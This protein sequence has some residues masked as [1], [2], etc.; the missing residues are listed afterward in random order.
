[1]A[2][3]L[4]FVLEGRDRLSRVL[5]G[6][7]TSASNLEKKLLLVSAAAP[8]AAALAPLIAQTGAAAVAV[9][10][11]G[12]AVIPQISALSDASDAQKK[13]QKAV[14]TSGTRSEAAVT[15]QKEYL[16]QMAAMPPASQR[17]AVALSDLK[18]QYKSWS[19]GLAKDTMPVFNKSLAVAGG[20]LPKLTPMVKGAATELDR[21]VTIAAGGVQSSGFARFMGTFSDFAV[22]S[23][24]R[25]N[26]GLVHLVRTLD[27]G[28]A[29][30]G[31]ARFMDFARAQG[32]LVADTLR[33]IAS[34]ALNL[35]QAS[36]QTGVGVLTLANAAARL[37]AAL[38]PGFIALLMQT[39]LAIRAVRLAISGVQLA[40]G[41]LT[42]VRTQIAAAGT[43]AIGASGG[44]ATLKAAFMA[45][46]LS[47]RTAV[48]ATGI[49][50]LVLGLIK[51]SSIG[52]KAP[53]DIDRMTTSIAKLGN[54]G[55]L[56]GEALRVLGTDMGSLSAAISTLD[57]P[58]VYESVDR[59]LT[60]LIGMDSTPDK[61]ANKVLDSLDESLANLVKGGKAD[62]AKVALD[63]IT[64]SMVKQGHSVSEVKGHM[65]NYQS[66]L[67]DAA[68]EAKLTAQSMGLFGTQAQQVQA[69]LDAQKLSADGLRQSIQALNDVNRQ[70]L[71]GMIGFEAAI[72]A[73]TKAAKDNAGALSMS[74]GQLNLNS[75][76][77][78]AAA[79]A[80]N[81]LAAKTDTATAAAR[82]QGKAW[83]AIQD[84]YTR[85]RNKLIE[86][87]MAMGLTASQAK[88]LADQILK[89]PSKTAYLRGNVE[90]LD[91]KLTKARKELKDPDLTKTRKAKLNADIAELLQ[92][93][94]Q[95]Q[96]A[97]DSL[98]GKTVTL[99]TYSKYVS[100]GKQ[101]GT[102]T[103][104]APGR[105]AGGPIVGPGTG[106][107]DDVP[108]MASNG[109]Y[110]VRSAAVSKYG[111]KFL[112]ALNNG[113]LRAFAKGG[114]VGGISKSALSSIRTDTGHRM[115]I[116]L[117]ASASQINSMV[118]ELVGDI[119]RAFKGKN[120]RLDDHLVAM[121]EKGNKRLKTL[122]AE[123]DSIAKKI[124]EAKAFASSTAAT[125]RGTA[126]LSSLG[127]EALTGHGG[128]VVAGLQSKLANLRQFSRYVSILAKR[129]LNKT[130]LREILEM[131]PESGFAY[132]SEL[133]GSSQ[134]TISEINGIQ[135]QIGKESKAL[136]N[137][138]A[139][140]L[141]DS[142]KNAGKGFLA[143]LAGQQK[144]IEKL[145]LSIATGM[146]KAIRKALDINSPSRVM[147]WLGARTTDGLGVGAVS[148]IPALKQA[149]AKV[150][151][152][153]AGTS[154]A[155]SPGI[156]IGRPAGIGASAG[157]TVNITINGAMDPVA[158]GREIR[159]VLL[160]LKRTY[161]T[162]I[163][164][165]VA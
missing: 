134:K 82:D 126:A 27:T 121:L 32:P 151:D 6:A 20:L 157:T 14:D 141:Y 71:G 2:Q 19:D 137:K 161:G 127:E 117:T 51:L 50:L 103:V 93:K 118:K 120:T 18:D 140:L 160:E 13:Y 104:L 73:T 96:A 146:Q 152:A 3:T 128:G 75:S 1:M 159:R 54:G 132:A 16:R 105:A 25:A 30:S 4:T 60:G 42:L 26:D 41:G 116:E 136:G 119:Q 142:G 80:L 85:G 44:I 155:F 5:D 61:G 98:H 62:L 55:K 99:T 165:G 39:A 79:T 84:I 11:F 48:A 52:E 8:A 23:L 66:A 77:A 131:G 72:D 87:A 67:D 36:S 148:R 114:R 100:V 21:F 70:G 38:P 111:L 81:D 49:G 112:D 90:D 35:L 57:K 33:N 145:M 129:H 153:V 10:A 122:A 12:A 56:S 92:K 108:I 107:S 164:L 29:E 139:D 91:A 43:A 89:T 123:R 154:M 47:A 45:M 86:S 110:M 69:K 144:A 15:A 31:V 24:R 101:P 130:M 163:N 58:S 156:A 9:A 88:K 17:A 46:S 68:L 95:A 65:D 162:N 37:V 40:A 133:V 63:Q 150:S 74:H 124:A 78:Q 125:A 34:A 7:G 97:I 102:G 76:K 59:F 22:G 147:A 135:S 106:T 28:A 143:G 138:G 158:V 149:M 64:A 53:P 94:R 109:E 113:T 83:S 115:V